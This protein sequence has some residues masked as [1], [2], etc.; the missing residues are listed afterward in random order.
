MSKLLFDESSGKTLRGYP[1]YLEIGL[2]LWLCLGLFF[3]LSSMIWS[4]KGTTYITRI[5]GGW[6][7]PSIIFCCVYWR[8]FVKFWMSFWPLFLFFVSVLLASAFLVED[9]SG[10]GRDIKAILSLVF[11]MPVI[12]RLMSEREFLVFDVVLFVSGVVVC[13]YVLVSSYALYAGSIVSM[14]SLYSVFPL[15]ANPLYMSQYVGALGVFCLGAGWRG[16]RNKG[17]IWPVFIM[18]FAILSFSAFVTL[19]RSWL[20]AIALV[21][22]VI[23]FSTKR[24]LIVVA[25]GGAAMMLLWFFK[26]EIIVKGVSMSHR[27]EIWIEGIR[28]GIAR[29]LGQGS[30]VELH[31][32]QWAEPHNIFLTIWMMYGVVPVVLFVTSIVWLINSARLRHPEKYFEWLLPLVFGFGMLFFEGANPIHRPNESWMLIWIPICVMIAGI[33]SANER[34]GPLFQFRKV[35]V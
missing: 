16:F 12:V 27:D 25:G 13:S 29:P 3:I 33:K 28:Q 21:A 31:V 9:S 5:H 17:M 11:G 2:G 14:R 34:P 8:Y 1:R 32:L 22:I 7:L 18:M 23:L 15:L 4:L 30:G 35:S 24:L 19:S 20:V 26:T 6:L 10:F